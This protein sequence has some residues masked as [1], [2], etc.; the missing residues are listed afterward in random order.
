MYTSNTTA[1]VSSASMP[2][3]SVTHRLETTASPPPQLPRKSSP[4]NKRIEEEEVVDLSPPPSY[5]DFMSS[6][7]AVVAPTVP[8]FSSPPAYT[9]TASS[10]TQFSISDEDV[11]FGTLFEHLTKISS[12]P[13][14]AF[15]LRRKGSASGSSGEEKS[16]DV[17]ALPNSLFLSHAHLS[18]SLSDPNMISGPDFDLDSPT[19]SASSGS[20]TGF[21]KRSDSVG[22]MELVE[23]TQGK[24]K[25]FLAQCTPKDLKKIEEEKGFLLV[26]EVVSGSKAHQA[27]VRRNDIFVR[28]GPFHAEN[29]PGLGMLA[30]YISKIG[31]DEIHCKVIRIRKS[32]KPQIKELV[33]IPSRWTHGVVLGMV[34]DMYE[35]VLKA[36]KDGA[37]RICTNVN[38]EV[39]ARASN[40]GF[41]AVINKDTASSRKSN[42]AKPKGKVSAPANL[43]PAAPKGGRSRYS[44]MKLSISPNSRRASN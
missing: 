12:P 32:Q 39:A 40:T 28:F 17:P 1:Q 37:H 11:K 33:L 20:S 4:W 2:V 24:K 8:R 26:T 23:E 44:N 27:G 41:T 34:V 21:A 13:M 14:S 18:R 9:S 5:Y 16:P 6:G 3:I 30:K 31:E 22:S 38:C 19:L 10:S 29:F 42:Y 25:T 15:T 43:P 35:K 7:S 36:F